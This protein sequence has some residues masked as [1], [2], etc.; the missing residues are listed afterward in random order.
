MKLKFFYDWKFPLVRKIS[1]NSHTKLFQING[2]LQYA[3]YT[4][5]VTLKYKDKLN[6]NKKLFYT[7][8]MSTEKRTKII[9]NLLRTIRLR[10]LQPGAFTDLIIHFYLMTAQALYCLGKNFN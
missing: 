6:I 8:T 2:T 9:H 5:E 4:H 10:L 1:K 7:A 3:H